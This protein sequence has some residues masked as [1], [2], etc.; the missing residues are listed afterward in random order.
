MNWNTVIEFIVVIVVMA[1]SALLLPWLKEKLGA[2]KMDQLAQLIAIAVQAAEQIF[3]PATGERK[4][5]YVVGFLEQ[6]GVKADAAMIDA[7]IE[8]EVLNLND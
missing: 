5:A 4:K 3:G 6:Q 7:M 1:V 2:E 8:A